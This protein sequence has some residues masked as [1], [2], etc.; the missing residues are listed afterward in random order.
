MALPRSTVILTGAG[1]SAESGLGTFRDEDGIWTRYSLEDL[2]TPEGFARNPDFVQGFYN[3][4]RRQ[5]QSARPNPAHHALSRLET[6][7]SEAGR[8]FLLITQN[9]DN[10]HEKAGSRAVAHMH[11]EL[12]KIRCMNCNQ[13]TAWDEDIGRDSACA[14]CQS[15]GYLRPHVVWFGEIPLEMDRIA[16]TLAHCALFV[17]IGTSGAVYPAAGFVQEARYAGARTVELNLEPSEIGH[18]FDEAHHGPASEVVPAW[19][20]RLIASAT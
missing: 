20:D 17:S 10:L 3:D 12:T 16:S 2:A 1:V 7:L 18:A 19:V 9:I 5:L 8:D 15:R 13:I 14:A 6:A 11:G 4:R